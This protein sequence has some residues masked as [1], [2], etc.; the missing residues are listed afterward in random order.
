MASDSLTIG[1]EPFRT[2]IFQGPG[3][4]VDFIYQNVL[5]NHPGNSSKANFFKIKE[6]L[7]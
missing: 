5:N 3:N 1:A 7:P 4:D 6:Q 2:L